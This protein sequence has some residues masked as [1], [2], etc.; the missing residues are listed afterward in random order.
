MSFG[1]AGTIVE[2]KEDTAT[3]KIARLAEAGITVAE[4]ISEIPDIVKAK[5]AEQERRH[6]RRPALFIDVEVDDVGRE[7]PRAGGE[8][9]PRSAPS[10]SSPGRR[11]ASVEIVEENLDE[12]V[13]CRLC[14]DAPP[15]GHRQGQEALRRRRRTPVVPD[16]PIYRAPMRAREPDLSPGVGAEYGLENGLVGIGDVAGRMVRRFAELPDGVFVWTR[17]TGSLYHLGRINGPHRR[18]DSA[19]R[20]R[21]REST[22][23]VPPPGSTACSAR[24]RSPAAVAETLRSRRAQLPADPQRRG[25]AADGGVVGFPER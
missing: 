24:T 14:I 7:R 18:E 22:T 16:T 13:L 6:E 15:P 3:E 1:H 5:M 10:T 8:A 25:R 19:G 17:D 12:C 11:A 4:E 2:G 20:P 21:R 23:S 9:R